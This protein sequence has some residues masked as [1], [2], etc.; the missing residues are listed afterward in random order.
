[1]AGSHM[2]DMTMNLL[3]RPVG[4]YANVDFIP[5]SKID[6]RATALFEYEDGTVV[7]FEAITSPHMKTGYEK[8]GWDEY[9]Q[10]N[11]VNG[12]LEI[13]FVMWDHPENNGALLIHYDNEKETS[14]EYRFNAVNPFEA[15][16]KYFCDCLESRQ[17]GHPSVDDGLNVDV[18]ID[19]ILESTSKK[20]RIDLNWLGL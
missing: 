13:Y 17:Q 9:I 3:G 5:N 20:V 4:V 1:M 8:N 6:R 11:G 2:I 7:S 10:I 14:T 18:V 19:A 15:E 12:R 16:I